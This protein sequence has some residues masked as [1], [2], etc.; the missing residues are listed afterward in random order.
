MRSEKL[1]S[2]KDYLSQLSP[3]RRGAKL[4]MAKAILNNLEEEAVALEER[5][6]DIRALQASLR[7]AIENDEKILSEVSS[8]SSE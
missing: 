3:R 5:L 7:E 1:K 2:V 8:S 6:S 4:R